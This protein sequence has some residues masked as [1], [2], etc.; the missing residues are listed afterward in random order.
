MTEQLG[1]LIHIATADGNELFFGDPDFR[2]LT[3]SGLG[4]ADT[5]FITRRGY[6]QN[7]S[8]E[9]D[10]LLQPRTITVELW[11]S[12]ACDR[13]TY[14]NNRAELHN[15]LRP[16]RNGPITFTL[17]T[18]NGDLRSIVV[19]A[20]PGLALPSQSGNNNWNIQESLDFIAF[21]PLFFNSAQT[22]ITLSSAV[23]TQLVFPITFPISFGTSDVSLTTGT[24]TYTGT[25]K[26]YP[27]ITLAG[28]YTRA[29]LNQQSGVTIYMSVAIAAGETRIIDLTP[30]AQSITDGNGVNKFSD[31]GVGS[32]LIDFAILPDPEI[33]HGIQ[34]ITIQL[35]GGTNGVSGA[36]LNYYERFFAL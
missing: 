29:V 17:R 33:A 15:F 14:W 9:I 4:A 24:I 12:P 18:P 30:G 5:Q 27:I 13:Q 32:N 34:A 10:Y 21:D 6:K 22:A 28:P 36:S 1:D 19:R 7:G 35:V 20:D 16:N 26:S 23:Q 2:L 25:W 31:L 11:R 3:Y 8:T